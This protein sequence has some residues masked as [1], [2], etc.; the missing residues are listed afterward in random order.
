LYKEWAGYSLGPAKPEITLLYATMYG[1]T[2][3]LMNAVARGIAGVGVPMQIFD[4]AHTHVSYI[5]PSLYARRG[6]VVGAPTYE[7]S[8]FPIMASV[9]AMADLKHLAKKKAAYFG[10][11][12]WSGGGQ[13]AFR[14]LIEPLQWDVLD[15][16]VFPGNPTADDLRKGEAFGATF[17]QAIKNSGMEGKADG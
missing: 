12:G 13:G 6:V 17:A 15:E 16:L 5:L 9:L 11:Y 2:E 14:K 10:S 4:V 1:A 8:L 7:G 3:I